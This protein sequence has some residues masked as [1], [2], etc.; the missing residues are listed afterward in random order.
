[1]IANGT[2]IGD[3][4]CNCCCCCCCS[5]QAFSDSSTHRS[6]LPPKFL[7]SLKLNF[8]SKISAQKVATKRCHKFHQQEINIGSDILSALCLVLI[9]ACWKPFSASHQRVAQH[10]ETGRWWEEFESPKSTRNR[11]KAARRVSPVPIQRKGVYTVHLPC[12]LMLGTSDSH[13]RCHGQSRSG[14]GLPTSGKTPRKVRGVE[15]NAQR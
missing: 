11:F 3:D 15:M 1:M 10:W 12:Q 5:W 8:S 6:Q 14:R 2:H 4:G 9:P 13:T 7:R